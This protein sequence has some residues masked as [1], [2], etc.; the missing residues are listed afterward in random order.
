LNNIIEMI[1]TKQF[2]I[3]FDAMQTN[4]NY[5]NKFYQIPYFSFEGFLQDN[6]SMVSE[7]N[8]YNQIPYPSFKGFLQDNCAAVSEENEHVCAYYNNNVAPPH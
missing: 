1:T 2:Y 3:E 5:F 4:P 7:E 8:A 6:H